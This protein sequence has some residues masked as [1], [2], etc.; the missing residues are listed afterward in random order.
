MKV[1]LTQPV[2]IDGEP[3]IHSF[4]KTYESDIIPVVGVEVEDT[5]WKDPGMYKITGF[6]MSFNE[7]AY[8]VGLEPY[9]FVILES[10]KDEIADMAKSHGWKASWDFR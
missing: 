9:E 5:L 6:Y 2:K 3:D 10:G 1:I 8:Y 4:T 7:N